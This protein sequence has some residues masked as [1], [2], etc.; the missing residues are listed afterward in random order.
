MIQSPQICNLGGSTLLISWPEEISTEILHRVREMRLTIERLQLPGI[1]E[2]FSTYCEIGIYY[3]PEILSE[4]LL[5]ETI[6]ELKIDANQPTSGK[7]W[8]LP[9]C[10]LNE[11]AVDLNGF[12]EAK[13]MGPE[14]VIQI[15]SETIYTLHFYGFLPGFMYLGGLDARLHI[16]RKSTPSTSVKRGSVAIGGSQTGIYPT[17]SPGG[18]HVIGYCPIPIFNVKNDPPCMFAPGDQIRFQPVSKDELHLI[19]LEIAT[20]I[21]QYRYE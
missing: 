18:W 20:E 14:E 10:Y 21:Y 5:K 17:S 2:T 16:P 6:L 13:K 4:H 19:E 15:H 7:L 8:T 11:Y 9:A 3:N 1:I 12:C